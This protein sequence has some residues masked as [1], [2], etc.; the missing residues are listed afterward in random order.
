MS[1]LASPINVRSCPS[2][3]NFRSKFLFI[4][5]GYDPTSNSEF[6]NSVDMYDHSKNT[7]SAAPSMNWARSS[8]STCV[9][10][11]NSVYAFFGYTSQQ[12]FLE[13]VEKLDVPSNGVFDNC[14]WVNMTLPS[15]DSN[16]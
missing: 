4:S 2:L 12:G 1:E 11:G 10:N 3:V 14:L 8:H 9:V 16:T 5:G 15:C 7:W 6:Y 13:S